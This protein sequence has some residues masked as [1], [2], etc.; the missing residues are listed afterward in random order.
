VADRPDVR[1]LHIGTDSPFLQFAAE[2]FEAVAPGANRYI[3][4]TPAGGPALHRPASGDI[5]TVPN[6]ARGVLSLLRQGADA[7]LIVAHAMTVHAAAVFARAGRRAATVWSGWGYDYYG[8]DPGD[9]EGLYGPLTRELLDRLAASRPA[10]SPIRSRVL[11]PWHSFSRRLVARAA[12]RAD[13][14]SAPVPTDEPVFRRR[15]PQFHGRYA[16]LS[17]ASLES[18]F[19]THESAAQAGTGILIGNSATP[20]NNHLEAFDLLA[21]RDLGGRRVIVPLSYGDAAYREAVLDRGAEALGA[22]F[23]PLVDRLPLDEYNA[24]VAGCDVV[25]M[26][27]RRQQAVGN[28]GTALQSG[29]QVVLDE[30]NPVYTFL[31]RQGAAVRS[32]AELSSPGAPF[33]GRLAAEQLAGNQEIVRSFWGEQRVRS[34]VS[35]LLELARERNSR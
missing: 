13:F 21:G 34:N 15:Y 23:L 2:A 32:T 20:S 26:N 29:A 33:G 4:V 5:V 22:A 14:F 8:D 3:V 24:L 25:I 7:D 35:A 18:S 6:S 1:I 28:I 12:R 10:A 19:D 27:T 16:Q 11:A 9:G 31:R 17:Y 30:A